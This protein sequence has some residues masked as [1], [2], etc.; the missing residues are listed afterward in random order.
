MESPSR[1]RRW[2]RR[3]TVILTVLIVVIAVA[4]GLVV[5]A[6]STMNRAPA[7]DTE[8]VKVTRSEQT[9]TVTLSGTLAPKERANASFAVPGT[10]TGISV[11][12]GDKVSA[13]DTL[14]TLDDTDLSNAVTL[15]EANLAAASAS[16]QG[17]RDTDGATSAQIAAADAQVE[18]M[19]A[20][21][22]SA[23]DRLADAALTAPMAGVIAEVALDVGDQ[24]SGSAAAPAPGAGSGIDL[25]ELTGSGASGSSAA[26][27]G[28]GQIV[29]IEPDTWKLDA[30]IGTADLPAIQEGQEAVVTPTG[31]SQNVS[32]VVDTIGIVATQTAGSV[33]SF[34]VTLTITSPDVTL[35]T[36]S[37]A[38]AVIVT[39]IV[40]DVLTVPAEAITY[41]DDVALVTLPD[42]STAE[43]SLGRRFGDRQEITSGLAA[44][45][46][47]LAPVGVA[48]TAAPR[49]R[50]GPNGTL[51]SPD[52]TE[53]ATP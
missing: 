48:S 20:N 41:V 17:V 15:A 1:P 51:A 19:R 53:S 45:D 3:R 16:A 4:I 32:A 22:T 5:W 9:A 34:P 37:E 31:T 38:D 11:S 26:G 24:V 40:A 52:S 12:V 27:T 8:V 47:I 7:A 29:I 30:T 18:A 25:S 10:V 21:V 46:E 44:G 43:V 39:D 23:R 33:A 49:I 13:G 42:Q 36:G 2:T 6:R 14:A 35:F 50:F 28:S